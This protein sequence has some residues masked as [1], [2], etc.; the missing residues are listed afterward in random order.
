MNQDRIR[1]LLR[2][3]ADNISTREEVEELFA[4]MK[5]SEADEQ[6]EQI[7]VA[8][9]E[10]ATPG[11]ALLPEDWERLWNNI[12]TSA[13]PASKK[14]TVVSFL[15]KSVAAAALLLLVGTALLFLLYKKREATIAA[16]DKQPYQNDIQPG[17]NKAVLTLADG[18]VIILDTAQNGYLANQNNTNIIKLNTGL[19]SYKKSG[20]TD[21]K[22]LYNTITTPRGGQYQVQLPDGTVVWLN[23]ESSLQFPTG[24]V[25]KQ[26]RV[27][28]KGEG[29][30]EVA[31]NAAMPFVVIAGKMDVLV[32]GTHFNIMSY[33]DE[34]NMNTTLLEG[35]INLTNNGITKNLQPGHQAVVSRST[36]AIAIS[37]ANV[38]QVMAWKNGEFRFKEAG[39]KEIMRQVSR[40]YNVDVEYQTKN[41]DQ[42]FTASLPRM[43]NVSALLQMLELTGTVH[44]KI[45][46]KKIIV[47]P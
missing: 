23:A 44:F 7:I 2:L 47:L 32:L 25:G 45:D 26:R 19:L 9:M 31:K 12:R 21:G 4:L 24:F 35:N 1:Q 46:H 3:Y 15:K 13:T 16:R 5:G 34:E 40:W 30:F 38:K 37:T 42:Y 14:A 6:L 29:Y 36:N 8:S 39:I 10:E 11:I 22:V 18:T 20:N 27:E 41:D 17:G 33:G 43:Q 28:L